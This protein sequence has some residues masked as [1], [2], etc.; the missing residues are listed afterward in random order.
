V[1]TT[2][3]SQRPRLSANYYLA[4]PS[5]RVADFMDDAKQA[6][7]EGVGLTLA[8]LG[9]QGPEALA[10]LAAEHGLFISSLNSAGYFLYADPAQCD[11]QRELN[12]RLIEAAARMRAGR[13]VVIAGGIAGSGLTLEAAR[14]RVADA[15]AA[16]DAEA[17]AAGV[18][19]ALEPIH[20][21]DLTT[22]GCI[23]SIRQA[24]DIVR[25]LSSTDIVID[26]FHTAWDP[27][28]WRE[29]VLGDPKLALVQVCDWYEPS[30]DEKPQRE[31]PTL[32]FMDLREWLGAVKTSGYAGPIEF[33]MFDRHRRG[34]DVKVILTEALSFL[35]KAL[36]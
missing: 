33:E 9:A 24:L 27:D 3:I 4:P 26:T 28:I 15:L 14:L 5:V 1:P 6:G 17:G 29:A 30:P 34:R 32:G 21:A 2:Q 25:D 35:H 11:R 10:Q 8:A 31:L 23:N 36:S 12:R 7:A 13:L 19:L 16:L 20:P 22:K 18:R